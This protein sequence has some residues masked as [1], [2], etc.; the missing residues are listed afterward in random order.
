MTGTIGK[1]GI[2]AVRLASIPKIFLENLISNGPP[3]N[4]KQQQ[5]IQ[6]DIKLPKSGGG[7]LDQ[8]PLP[9]GW[10]NGLTEQEANARLAQHGLNEFRPLPNRLQVFGEQ[11]KNISSLSLFGFGVLSLALGKYADAAIVFLLFTVLGIWSTQLKYRSEQNLRHYSRTQTTASVLREGRMHQ[12]PPAFVVPGDVIFLRQGDVVPAD[13]VIVRANHL[14]VREIDAD[15]TYRVLLKRAASQDNGLRSL[16]IHSA[17]DDCKLYAGSVVISGSAQALVTATGRSARYAKIL[18]KPEH[19]QT[20]TEKRYSQFSEKLAKY[21]WIT[22]FL[23]GALVLAAGW[24]GSA[25]LET[26]AAVGTSAI[27][28]GFTLPVCLAFWTAL[29]RTSRKAEGLPSMHHADRLEDTK[30]VVLS[31]Q[32]LIRE[33]SINKIWCPQSRWLVE[34]D[35]KDRKHSGKLLFYKNGIQGDPAHAPE[36]TALVQAAKLFARTR[37]EWGPYDK[38]VN[39]L[40]GNLNMAGQPDIRG[41]NWVDHRDLHEHGL[42]EMRAFQ[43]KSGRVIEVIRGPVEML[44]ESS[45]RVI[46]PVQHLTDL[47]PESTAPKSDS[48]RESLQDWLRTAR[49][50]HDQTIGFAC[51]VRDNRPIPADGDETG[52]LIWLGAIAFQRTY[53]SSSELLRRFAGLGLPIVLTVHESVLNDPGFR[54]AVAFDDANIKV[55]AAIDFIAGLETAKMDQYDLWIVLADERERLSTIQKLR[56]RFSNV[57]FIGCHDQER[58]FYGAAWTAIEQGIRQGLEAV[59]QTFEEARHA[60]ERIAH[61]NGFILSGNIGEVLYSVIAGLTGAHHAHS[62]INVN[63]LTNML[64]S[65]GL[66]AGL[67]GTDPNQPK[68]HVD[69]HYL[70]KP[71]VTHGIISGSTAMFSYAGGLLVSDDPVFASTF[72]FA[73]L[74]LSQLWQAL[75]WRRQSKLANLKDLWEDRVLAITLLGALGVLILSI[76]VP[77]FSQLLQ[78]S[79]LGLQDWLAAGAIAGAVGPAASKGEEA[80]WPVVKRIYGSISRFRSGQ[81]PSTKQLAAS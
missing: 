58:A 56:E 29:Q 9:G 39:R 59:L 13:S 43:D 52:D 41:W 72:A 38:A 4:S 78:T 57:S 10:E 12:I 16:R 24:P 5:A 17:T 70:H 35:L 44:F 69:L 79:P 64:A 48:I 75:H 37:G 81:F 80:I 18:R 15:S 33:M 73:A 20:Y 32:A 71:I 62:P 60:R 53:R 51:R 22:V 26:A 47:S 54:K 8:I 77:F 65:I 27:S 19:Q 68:K 45:H 25:A 3:Q 14:Q 49:R 63:I 28:G 36:C 6:R 7:Q 11:F 40:Y 30:V 21:G 74:I 61:A 50:H 76:H 46:S 31:E 23:T 1:M 34:P 42:F 2:W 55:L 66:A 67:R